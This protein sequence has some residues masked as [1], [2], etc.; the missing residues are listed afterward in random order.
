MQKRLICFVK[1]VV[2]CVAICL[3]F[4]ACARDTTTENVE[5]VAVTQEEE[6]LLE[7]EA[8]ETATEETKAE[9]PVVEETEA[10]ETEA[11]V[12]EETEETEAAETEPEEPSVPEEKK[13]TKRLVHVT[14]QDGWHQLYL[15]YNKSGLLKKIESIY[16][17]EDG[18]LAEYGCRDFVYKY[19]SKNRLL[20]V[21][22]GDIET[23]WTA[24]TLLEF[25]YDGKG[26]VKT[27]K[28]FA[29]PTGYVVINC[30]YDSQNRLI[31]TT[32]KQTD[33]IGSD[34]IYNCWITDLVYDDS[35]LLLEATDRR[36]ELYSY[37]YEK[38]DLKNYENYELD[39]ITKYEYDSQNRVSSRTVITDDDTCVDVFIYDHDP[40]VIVE[41]QE[42]THK[43]IEYFYD[44]GCF[45]NMNPHIVYDYL[46]YYTES[47]LWTVCS[48][49]WE[50][51]LASYEMLCEQDAFGFDDDGYFKGVKETADDGSIEYD[52][53]YIWEVVEVKK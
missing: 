1:V 7:T 45:T 50:S 49:S 19:D 6:I 32:G 53:E 13:V 16:V 21:E 38:S 35:G 31:Q 12:T 44:I 51:A 10:T 52:W 18:T 46:D 43:D 36:F 9:E 22:G 42:D 2:L 20:K 24:Y 14:D 27:F 28:M 4:A 25:V 34:Y 30:I 17:N 33:D 40:V 47:A 29:A 3:L 41:H 8:E 5:A 48:E 15:H 11:E 23:D 39:A 37:E 26:R